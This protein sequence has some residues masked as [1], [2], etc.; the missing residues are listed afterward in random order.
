MTLRFEPINL[1]RQADYLEI[2]S[3]CP[4]I[5]SD[6]SFLNLWAWAEEYGLR[7]AWDGDLIWIQQSLPDELLWAPMGRWD[8]VDWQSKFK[9][10]QTARSVFTRV[11]EILSNLWR[12]KM[13]PETLI[14]EERG[15]WDYLYHV[16][17]LIE[18][19]GNR[20]HKK[21]NL[22]INLVVNTILLTCLSDP[23]WLIR[24][25]RCKRTGA[26]GGI[27]NHRIFFRQKIALFLNF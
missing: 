27:A 12:E 11:P 20:Y 8:E 2:L 10:S 19:K 15:N 4:Q 23:S 5:A 18:L 24:Q 21:K 16:T 9:A 26:R 1:E 3:R 17:D 6:Y 7:W 25:W 13:P 22:L 14:E